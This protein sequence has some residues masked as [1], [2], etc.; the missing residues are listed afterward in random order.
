MREARRD[1]T[2]PIADADWSGLAS[3]F[4]ILSSSSLQLSVDCRTMEDSDAGLWSNFVILSS[5]ER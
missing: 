4:F 3:D 5:A 1:W 2:V